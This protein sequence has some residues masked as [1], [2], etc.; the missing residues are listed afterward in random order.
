[1]TSSI[2]Y[3]RAA[4]T[5]TEGSM[6]PSRASASS[7]ATTT[8]SASVLKYRRAAGRVSENP[9]PSVPRVT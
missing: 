2:R 6:A 3:S 7:T 8:D 5:A 4:A 9:N 1:M